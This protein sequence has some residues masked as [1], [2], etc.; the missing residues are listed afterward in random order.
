MWLILIDS[1]SRWPEVVPM[2]TT[3]IK[4]LRLIFATSGLPEQIFTDNGPQ[5]V[6]EEFT[7]SNGIQ[8]IKIASKVQ[9]NGREICANFQNSDEKDG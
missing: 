1:Y 3:T 4:E 8:H 6:S 9:R 7:R 5:F 2:R